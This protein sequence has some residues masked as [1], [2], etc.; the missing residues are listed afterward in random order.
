[1]PDRFHPQPPAAVPRVVAYQGV[2]GAYSEL[3]ARA[4]AAPGDGLLP[5]TSFA[6]M[7]DAVEQGAAAC[8]AAPIENTLAGSVREC[9]DLLALRAVTITGEALVRVSHALIGTPGA[10]TGGIR[11]VLSHPVALA[12][13]E[14]WFAA[15]P[16]IEPVPV[17]DTAG[18]VERVM[19]E[20]DPSQAALAAERAAERYGAE[21]LERAL[22][23]E[24]G[25]LTRFFRVARSGEGPA[26][27]HDGTRKTLLVFRTADRPGALHRCLRPFA[28]R[29]L[30]LT[31][32]E[33]RPLKD[34]PFEY[35]F[36]MEAT[37]P[38]PGR[39]LEEA[40]EELRRECSELH[41][42]G[43]FA[44]AGAPV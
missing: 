25:N 18:A 7:F 36:Y 37:D 9:Q 23:D 8:A 3:A 27:G 38:G 40:V 33:S 20:G 6:D 14:R 1:M 28:E 15:H 19:R 24:P 29:G 2:P 5:C 43:V 42:L 41:Q 12:Q 13:C 17:F 30:D 11:R 10:D 32:I 31:R 35:L 4:F 34:T 26:R 16:G 44:P 39:A 22:E 21:V